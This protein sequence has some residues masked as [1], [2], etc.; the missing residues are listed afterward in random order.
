MG[1]FFCYC[2][3]I[4]FL[5]YPE[6]YWRVLLGPWLLR[7]IHV[8]YDR[9]MRVAEARTAYPEF[10]TCVLDD[11][12]IDLTVRDKNAFADKLFDDHFYNLM[13]FSI[14]L[15]HSC[16]N[17]IRTV[18]L[19]KCFMSSH[20]KCAGTESGDGYVRRA[21]KKVLYGCI[22]SRNAEVVLSQIHGISTGDMLRL[23]KGLGKTGVRFVDASI[24][25]EDEETHETDVAMRRCIDMSDIDGEFL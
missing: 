4:S 5:N 23:K 18:V 11:V 3:Q 16:P 15:K 12:H 24:M 6:K 17:N 21:V 10:V 22:S 2:T 20:V 8:L 1:C 13:L 9:Y 7:F 25:L 19:D 14:I